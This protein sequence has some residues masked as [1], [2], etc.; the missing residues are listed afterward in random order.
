MGPWS[1][2]KH[3]PPQGKT[4]ANPLHGTPRGDPYDPG[5]RRAQGSQMGGTRI[6]GL[7]W[8]LQGRPGF[9]S[10]SEVLGKDRKPKKIDVSRGGWERSQGLLRL[11]GGATRGR[12]GEKSSPGCPGA[13]PTLRKKC[14]SYN[15]Q[16]PQ[17]SAMVRA[18]TRPGPRTWRISHCFVHVT[19]WNR[20]TITYAN[21]GSQM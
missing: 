10:S 5:V 1:H 14:F 11:W 19:N 21:A 8:I 2:G 18:L 17:L 6:D 20:Q 16:G 13:A 12:R 15:N 3:C 4:R 7:F 9:D